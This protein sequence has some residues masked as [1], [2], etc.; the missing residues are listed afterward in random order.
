MFHRLPKPCVLS[1]MVFFSTLATS[2]ALPQRA[3]DQP[4]PAAPAVLVKAAAAQQD[5]ARPVLASERDLPER[6][7]AFVPTEQ[8]TFQTIEGGIR[9]P[10]ASDVPA[11]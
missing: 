1:A 9:A 8:K 6:Q 3:S 2:E 11:P 7:Q 5:S 4:P 10:L